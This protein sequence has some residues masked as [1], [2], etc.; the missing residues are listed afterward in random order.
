MSASAWW[1]F[2]VD[3]FLKWFAVMSGGLSVLFM[4]LIKTTGYETSFAVAGWISIA[5]VGGSLWLKEHREVLR[6]RG[7]RFKTQTL[8]N[9][10]AL[11]TE[12]QDL[13]RAVTMF[14]SQIATDA[15]RMRAWVSKVREF[16]RNYFPELS[17]SF[18]EADSPETV[19][20]YITLRGRVHRYVPLLETL[21]GSL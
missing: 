14:A 8:M 11:I 17:A 2:P 1:R 5:V 20:E 9:L 19:D 4:L 21:R 10:T 18:Q 7:E 16:V 12:G 15:A 6:L 3:L 13:D